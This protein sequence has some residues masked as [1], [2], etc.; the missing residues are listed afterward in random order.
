MSKENEQRGNTWGEEDGAETARTFRDAYLNAVNQNR[1]QPRSNDAPQEK[2][3]ETPGRPKT[4]ALPR[5]V[6]ASA[7]IYEESDDQPVHDP[8]T[9]RQVHDQP[10]AR[11]RRHPRHPIASSEQ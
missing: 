9:T 6:P 4:R 3:P 8:R 2:P 11:F 7:R 1:S 5:G 10:L